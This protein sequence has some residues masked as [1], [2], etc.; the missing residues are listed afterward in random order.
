MAL[1]SANIIKTVR[2]IMPGHKVFKTA[3]R[4][5]E[6]DSKKQKTKGI[7]VFAVTD[8]R[9]QLNSIAEELNLS[10]PTFCAKRHCAEF[11]RLDGKVIARVTCGSKR[12]DRQIVVT[13]A[14]AFSIS[15][16]RGLFASHFPKDV[17]FD[18]ERA[19][20]LYL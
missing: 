17:T 10:R 20:E 9:K 4:R 19:Q 11:R 12:N 5:R 7:G 14:G 18:V 16:P 2:D 3:F 15:D 8:L 6:A 13:V 1:L